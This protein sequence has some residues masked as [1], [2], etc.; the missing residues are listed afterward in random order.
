[1]KMYWYKAVKGIKTQKRKRHTLFG[2]THSFWLSKEGLQYLI[3]ETSYLLTNIYTLQY[4]HGKNHYKFPRTSIL[5]DNSAQVVISSTDLQRNPGLLFLDQNPKH[6]LSSGL[7]LLPMIT[8]LFGLSRYEGMS[9]QSRYELSNSVQTYIFN[10]NIYI[11]LLVNISLLHQIRLDD[12]DP[13]QDMHTTP[14]KPPLGVSLRLN[15]WHTKINKKKSQTIALFPLPSI[16]QP[17]SN[18]LLVM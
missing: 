15:V 10:I 5:A 13:T 6:D 4:L 12:I 8:T 7:T 9:W 11:Y 2:S 16:W 1:M 18:L 17:R 3:F 14:A